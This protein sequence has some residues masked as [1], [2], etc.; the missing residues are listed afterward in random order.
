MA[1]ILGYREPRAMH[2]SCFDP[3]TGMYDYFTD[4]ESGVPINGDLP[5]PKLPSATQLGVAAIEVGRSLPANAQRVGRGWQARG[6]IVQCGR[7][8]MGL[9]GSPDG[10]GSFSEYVDW[11]KDGGWKWV[12]AAGAAG[13]LVMYYLRRQ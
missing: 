1:K 3:S 12:A 6:Q 7:N 9:S 11:L 10:L 4:G 5:V 8:P 2:Y 13:V